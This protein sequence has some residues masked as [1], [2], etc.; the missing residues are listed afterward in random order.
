MSKIAL[1]IIQQVSKQAFNL[2]VVFCFE[3]SNPNWRK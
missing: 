1:S 3:A 2:S